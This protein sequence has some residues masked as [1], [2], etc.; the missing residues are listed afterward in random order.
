[1]D[2]I[3][4][5]IRASVVSN[6]KPRFSNMPNFQSWQSIDVC[7]SRINGPRL[8]SEFDLSTKSDGLFHRNKS[9]V[10][11]DPYTHPFIVQY[12]N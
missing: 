3:Y 12:D 2:K 6:I 1:M 9:M 10:G 8:L 4:F 7:P 5:V 11:F